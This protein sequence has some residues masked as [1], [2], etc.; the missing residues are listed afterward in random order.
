M[1][2]LIYFSVSVKRAR[3][4]KVMKFLSMTLLGVM[5]LFAL[6]IQAQEASSDKGADPTLNLIGEL[7]KVMEET[8]YQEAQIRSIADDIKRAIDTK[9]IERLR[10]RFNEMQNRG[11]NS[12]TTVEE[13]VEREA[14]YRL[15]QALHYL[16]EQYDFFREDQKLYMEFLETFLSNEMVPVNEGVHG[17]YYLYYLPNTDIGLTP[18]ARVA[19]YWGDVEGAEIVARRLLNEPRINVNLRAMM[20]AGVFMPPLHLAVISTSNPDF[21]DEFLNNKRVDRIVTDISIT[22]LLFGTNLAIRALSSSLHPE[23]IRKIIIYPSD[24]SG[25]REMLDL[26]V[27]RLSSSG[28]R[29]ADILFQMTRLALSSRMNERLEESDSRFSYAMRLANLPNASVAVN[30]LLGNSHISDGDKIGLLAEIV[31]E[32]QGFLDTLFKKRGTNFDYQLQVESAQR[33]RNQAIQ[34]LRAL[35]YSE[36]Q[37]EL[38]SRSSSSKEEVKRKRGSLQRLF[39]CFSG[40]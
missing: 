33:L 31:E 7:P 14:S 36:E 26:S 11:V 16:L 17:R 2:V 15:E 21:V 32:A 5:F 3:G 23:I 28:S 35:K 8:E 27:E 4:E 24:Q 20:R 10:T 9:D 39:G 13:N 25:I 40:Q 1:M 34:A 37:R 38:E 29:A 19:K 12:G 6:S 18:L 22:N 30:S